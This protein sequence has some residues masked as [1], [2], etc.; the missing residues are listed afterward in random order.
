METIQA[1]TKDEAIAKGWDVQTEEI[2]AIVETS[3]VTDV[4]DGNV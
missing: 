4:I 2:E 1:L 3:S